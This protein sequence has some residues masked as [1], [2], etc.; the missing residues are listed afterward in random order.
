MPVSKLHACREASAHGVLSVREKSSPE[1][2]THSQRGQGLA[3]TQVPCRSATSEHPGPLATQT[4]V[5]GNT[6]AVSPESR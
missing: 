6:P 1:G 5:D 4:L 3:V 2:P